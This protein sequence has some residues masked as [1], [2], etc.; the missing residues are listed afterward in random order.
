MLGHALLPQPVGEEADQ[1][2]QRRNR[3]EDVVVKLR[4]GR[5]NQREGKGRPEQRQRTQL[6]RRLAGAKAGPPRK[7]QRARNQRDPGEDA[8]AALLDEIDRE[9]IEVVVDEEALKECLAFVVDA[10]KADHLQIP[11]TRD[12]EEEKQSRTE[13]HALHLQPEGWHRLDAQL[14]APS[15]FPGAKPP[16]V[17][18]KV[19]A[20]PRRQ[21]TE[22]SVEDQDH[23][24][25]PSPHQPLGEG[26]EPTE[27]VEA[28]PPRGPVP[29]GGVELADD[30]AGHR[31]AERSH[32]RHVGNRLARKKKIERH[33]PQREGRSQPGAARGDARNRQREQP[34][35]Q[36]CQQ[37]KR[38]A[39]R[40]LRV[41]RERTVTL[42]RAQKQQPRNR[43]PHG[44]DGLGEKP[45]V[46]PERMD[47]VPPD[48]HRSG[49]FP[50]LRLPRVP[51][52]YRADV[53]Q[54]NQAT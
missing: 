35:A 10:L 49:N 2:R 30:R 53:R 33:R 22:E 39:H 41:S 44:E 37:R 13:A 8:V 31:T 25:D 48:D 18:R 40:P 24:R 15:I 26:R 16:D 43:H 45:P 14:N 36:H 6:A 3:R 51:E 46:L 32:E 19:V 42:P 28:V 54:K 7:H 20:I 27:R 38:K 52:A 1:D 21:H 34:E 29:G 47:V 12:G 11:G 50:V 17:G 5:G 4:R 9:A 23:R